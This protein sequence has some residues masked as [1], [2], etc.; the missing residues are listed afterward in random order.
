MGRQVGSCTSAVCQ[1]VGLS[2]SICLSACF[3]LSLSLACMCVS[4]QALFNEG[5]SNVRR[6]IMMMEKIFLKHYYIS[7]ENVCM[8]V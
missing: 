2:R 1:L 6:G 8:Y 7:A 3:C 4:V 5:G